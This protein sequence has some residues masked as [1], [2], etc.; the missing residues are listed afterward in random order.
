MHVRFK[1]FFLVAVLGL[2]HAGSVL[3]NWIVK[4]PY[5]ECEPLHKTY[6]GAISWWRV[7]DRCDS[8]VAFDE[9]GVDPR[10]NGCFD[11]VYCLLTPEQGQEYRSVYVKMGYLHDLAMVKKLLDLSRSPTINVFIDADYPVNFDCEVGQIPMDKCPHR[12]FCLLHNASNDRATYPGLRFQRLRGATGYDN[13]VYARGNYHPKYIEVNFDQILRNGKKY[14]ITYLLNGSY[15]LTVA[16]WRLNQEAVTV[17]YKKVE[18]QEEPG[19]KSSIENQLKTENN[20]VVEINNAMKPASSQSSS[21]G[22]SVTPKVIVPKR[23]TTLLGNMTQVLSS[24]I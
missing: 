20:R 2:F 16:A 15:N 7:S 24:E 14:R 9:W 11:W 8:D 6:Q 1:S 21:A 22:S 3:G 12:A 19:V 18:L 5:L 13:N 10:N 17:L 23:V 4:Q